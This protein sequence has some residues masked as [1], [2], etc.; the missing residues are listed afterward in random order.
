[1]SRGAELPETRQRVRCLAKCL[2][3]CLG[4]GTAQQNLSTPS[5]CAPERIVCRSWLAEA[6]VYQVLRLAFPKVLFRNNIALRLV[7]SVDYLA[8]N[9]TTIHLTL[10]C[11]GERAAFAHS[12]NAAFP[13]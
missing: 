1:M 9:C 12:R 4:R 8:S 13:C 10:P 5:T 3:I 6:G 2:L 11:T 7:G